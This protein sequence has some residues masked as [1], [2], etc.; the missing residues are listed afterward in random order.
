M[1]VKLPAPPK[2]AAKATV[3]TLKPAM[4]VAE[5]GKRDVEGRS[6]ITSRAQAGSIASTAF[7]SL[8][9]R[10]VIPD[11]EALDLLGYPGG[12]TKKGT[13]PRFKLTGEEVE[14]FRVLQEIDGALP[15][16]K[17]D[18]ATWFQQPNRDALFNGAAPLA[19]LTRM[20]LPGARSTIRFLLQ[21]GLAMS[22]LT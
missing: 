20:R 1:S 14:M 15:P 22:M 17:L 12:L 21:H 8:M 6:P 7:W 11:K 4:P 3:V 10:W 19:F 18:P 16:L 5:T 13:R 9:D 2:H